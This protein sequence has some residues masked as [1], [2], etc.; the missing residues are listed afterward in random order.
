MDD[1]YDDAEPLLLVPGDADADV[2]YPPM[3]RASLGL[4]YFTSFLSSIQY[5]ILMPTVWEYVQ[6]CGGSKFFLGLVLSAFS[7]SQ[8]VFFPVLGRWSDARAMREPF[9]ASFVLGTIGNT[10]YGMAGTFA[11]LGVMMAGRLVSGCG[12]ANTG[13]VAAYIARAAPPEQRTKLLGINQMVIFVGILCG[14]AMSVLVY[15]VDYSYGRLVLDRRTMAGYLMTAMNLLAML[16]FPLFFVEP[17]P[18]VAQKA[19]GALSEMAA[20]RLSLRRVFLERKGYFNLMIT[21][22]VAFEISALEAAITPITTDEYGWNAK[23]NSFLF[24]GIAGIALAA[25][26]VAIM[27]DKKPWTSP[28]GIVAGGFVTMSSSFVVAFVCAGGHRVPFYALC[29]FGSLFVGG[30]MML[31]ASNMA[32]YSTK[33]GEYGKGVFMGYAQIMQGTARIFGPLLAGASLHWSTHWALFSVLAIVFCVGPLNFWRVWGAFHTDG[34]HG[35]ADDSSARVASVD[36]SQ[37]PPVE[38]MGSFEGTRSRHSR[39]IEA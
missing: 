27:L 1:S 17:R 4:V 24:A 23:Q 20:W 15:D 38:R 26:A 32:V 13:L 37:S 12:A 9:F 14:P 22:I 39:D 16:V 10:I 25:V 33:I 29:T 28:R 11:S 8:T 35:G 2:E 31:P 30:V 36:V 5:A 6:L 7:L 21:F 3:P 34:E 18:Q 19:P